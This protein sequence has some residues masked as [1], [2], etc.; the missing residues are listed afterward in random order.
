MSG[1]LEK[2]PDK[3]TGNPL[4][5]QNEKWPKDA[6]RK[7]TP[8]ECCNQLKTETPE[9]SETQALETDCRTQ[10]TELERTADRSETVREANRVSSVSGMTDGK[11]DS[12]SAEAASGPESESTGRALML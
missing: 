12:A 7:R 1:G 9:I 6:V 3:F 11:R 4:L 5:R 10:Q 8:N 2:R